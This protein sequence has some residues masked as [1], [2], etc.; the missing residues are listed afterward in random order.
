MSARAELWM[1]RATF[2]MGIGVGALLGPP[3]WVGF[4]LAAGTSIPMILY[5]EIRNR[6]KP[7]KSNLHQESEPCW[8]VLCDNC[9][10]G[11]AGDEVNYYHYPTQSELEQALIDH[12]WKEIGDGRW[13]CF[14][15]ADELEGES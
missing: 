15:C 1:A 7:R 6:R 12:D 14:S 3:R 8:Y 5:F 11:D 13:L 9:G 2:F 4:V 10:E